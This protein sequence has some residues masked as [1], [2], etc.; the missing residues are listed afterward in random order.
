M[1]P[2]VRRFLASA[3]L[4]AAALAGPVS[5]RADDASPSVDIV[6]FGFQPA[7]IQVA[8][9]TA[10][11]WTNHDAIVHSVTSG[12][13]DAPDGA[14]DSGLFD[15]DMQYTMTFDSPGAYSYF[16]TRHP[17]MHATVTVS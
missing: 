10:V 3:T 13:P 17:F 7:D 15:Q 2:S 11:V 1:K 14:F 9:G 6:Q 16:C 8:A 5:A 4:V 12:T